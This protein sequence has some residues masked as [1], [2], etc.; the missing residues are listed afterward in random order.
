MAYYERTCSRCGH[1]WS[2]TTMAAKGGL[3][4][5]I[6]GRLRRPA[7][8]ENDPVPRANAAS[9]DPQ[10]IQPAITPASAR[11]ALS[12]CPACGSA[13]FTQERRAGRLP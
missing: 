9:D 4:S 5:A 10:R 1:R 3:M 11:E 12:H 6:F 13:D 8:G 2:V 7:V